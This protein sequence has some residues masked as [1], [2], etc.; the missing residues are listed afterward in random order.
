[1]ATQLVDKISKSGKTSTLYLR[2]FGKDTKVIGMWESFHGWYWYAT[3]I[4]YKVDNDIIYFG[5]VQGFEEEWGSFSSNDLKHPSIRKVP[6]TN[7]SFSGRGTHIKE[8][9]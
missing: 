1:M 6:K 7:W 3:E 2:A 9:L 4:E 8:Q 5:F